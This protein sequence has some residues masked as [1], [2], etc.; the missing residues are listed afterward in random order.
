MDIKDTLSSSTTFTKKF[1]LQRQSGPVNLG[2][3]TYLRSEICPMPLAFF[4]FDIFRSHFDKLSFLFLPLSEGGVC[5]SSLVSSITFISGNRKCSSLFSLQ[6]ESVSNAK[7]P[8]SYIP[9]H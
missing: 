1:F 3:T 5:S 6:S 2:G 7:I 9:D 4:S 8:S